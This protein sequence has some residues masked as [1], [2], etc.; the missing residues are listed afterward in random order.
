MLSFIYLFAS[1]II[2][3][4][5]RFIL[6]NINHP[7]IL[8][9]SL[10]FLLVAISSYEP[11]F[12]RELQTH[13]SIA[14]HVVMWVGGL[15]ILL[16]AYVFPSVGKYDI[17]KIYITKKYRLTIDFLALCSVF[18]FIMR[19]KSHILSPTILHTGLGIDIKELVPPGITGLHYIDLL[20]PII[21]I[22]Y[23]FEL[24]FSAV[25]TRRRITVIVFYSLYTIITIA[26]YKVSRDELT[27]YLAGVV[28]LF[29]IGRP[30]HRIR[31]FFIIAIILLS[32]VLMTMSRLSDNS[33]VFSQFS[34]KWGTVFSI[35][36]TYTAYNFENVN[37]LVNSSFHETYI[38]SSL[39]FLL[40]F[41]Y[42][43]DYELNNF[44]IV[45]EE[46]SFF[47]AKTYLYFFY[48]DLKLLGVFIYSFLIGLFIQFFYRKAIRNTR[49][50]LI[51]AVCC[52][53]L[54]F[55]FFGNFFF[56]DFPYFF[57]YPVTLFFTILLF[58]KVHI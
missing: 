55:M 34:G 21:G 10:W 24:M 37:K 57:V 33:A 12:N 54:F 6:K 19:F 9:S 22:C 8:A 15:S 29:Y 47:N 4:S 28:F 14:T 2:L 32:V 18:V 44:H 35:F 16:P 58:R 30:R 46:S 36:Y 27:Q 25:L 31:F 3:I 38:W 7:L 41:P 50:L 5:G 17:R 53:G 43:S 1:F 26:L 20:T 49:Y 52:K 23:F 45:M 39:K 51:I 11:W 13:W 56:V 42:S 40:R 48:H